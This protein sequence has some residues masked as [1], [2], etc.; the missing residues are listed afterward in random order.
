MHINGIDGTSFFEQKGLI[1]S[2]ITAVATPDGEFPRIEMEARDTDFRA[3]FAAA[4]ITVSGEAFDIR[5]GVRVE[6]S[7]RYNPTHGIVRYLDGTTIPVR[8][9]SIAIQVDAMANTFE[10]LL[11]TSALP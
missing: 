10:L 11:N 5:D 1:I 3:D 9:D 2:K 8:V 4:Q 6:I 7:R